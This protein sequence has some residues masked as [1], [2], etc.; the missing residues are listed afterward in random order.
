[1]KTLKEKIEI[2]QAYLD[3]EGIEHKHTGGGEW[4]KVNQEPFFQWSD[5]DY[6]IKPKPMVRYINIYPDTRTEF[7]HQVEVTAINDRVDGARTVKFIEV[8]DD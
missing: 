4:I 2:M 6:Q 7:L 5:W 1:M 8:M 3:G